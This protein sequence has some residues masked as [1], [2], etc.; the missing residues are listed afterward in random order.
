MKDQNP[1]TQEESYDQK[2]NRA[3]DLFTES[4]IKPD[5]EL[6]QCAHN[7]KCFH[8]LMYVRHQILEYLPTLRKK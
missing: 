4:V 5:P 2:W 8:E 1:I 7:Q 6:R 3:L